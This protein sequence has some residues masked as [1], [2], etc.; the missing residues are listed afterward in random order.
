M[1]ALA[2]PQNLI[3]LYMSKTPE[4][5]TPHQYVNAA[6]KVMNGIEL[7]PASCEIANQVVKAERYYTKE[8]DGL[9]QEWICRSLWL[10][11]PYGRQ[12]S[13]TGKVQLWINKLIEEYQ[14]GNVKEAILLVN[15]LPS[16]RWFDPLWQF[17]I[18][19]VAV[20]ISFYN[21][22]LERGRDTRPPHG[23]AIVYLGANEQRFIE[24][25]SEFGR[26]A[27]AIDPPKTKLV[28]LSLWEV[29]DG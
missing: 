6:R 15:A 19:F 2:K 8:D 13:Q 17:P 7:D 22:K 4:W 24:I 18:C 21:P 10:N 28:P 1:V 5:Y 25:F 27:K 29:S 11:P 16:Y 20:R 26:I 3:A 9:S 23:N 14:R 12:D